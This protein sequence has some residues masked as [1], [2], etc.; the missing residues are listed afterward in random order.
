MYA[1]DD[2]IRGAINAI[3]QMNNNTTKEVNKQKRPPTSRI[4]DLSMNELFEQ[5]EN[6]KVH[7]KFLT[8]NAMC[9]LGEKQEIMGTIKDIYKIISSRTKPT[10]PV[11]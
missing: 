3:V 10:N 8:D 1:G 11:S 4:E 9:S 7:L 6:H 5:M 2:D